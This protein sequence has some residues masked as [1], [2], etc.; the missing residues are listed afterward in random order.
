MEEPTGPGRDLQRL[1]ELPADGSWQANRQG[2]DQVE[3][4]E[5]AAGLDRGFAGGHRLR[6]QRHHAGADPEL[7]VVLYEK[8]L[9][10]NQAVGKANKV[11]ADP[12]YVEVS[13][14]QSKQQP[15]FKKGGTLSAAPGNVK[16]YTDAA[17]KK[18]LTGGALTNAQLTGKTKIYLRGTAPGKFK[19]KLAL[20]NPANARIQLGPEA[21]VE[22]GVVALGLDLYAFDKSDPPAR[23]ALADNK[24]IVPGGVI[25]VQESDLHSRAKLVLQK[26]DAADWPAGT[27]A[28]YEVVLSATNASGAAKLWDAETG[29]AEKALPLKIRR[30]D[31]TADRT[32]WLGQTATKK[33]HDIRIDAGV[34]TKRNGDWVRLTVVRIKEVKPAD[35]DAW[36]RASSRYWMRPG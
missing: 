12:T 17:C 25:H 19:L 10:A 13:F 30:T 6:D 2:L 31:L 5:R 16:F 24:K 35:A 26:V 1:G 33:L 3:C 23:T 32:Y 28:F 15:A 20:E 7:R 4:L 11:Y 22:M 9:S 34:Q 21:E 14:T 36:H 18:E 8:E 29:G 27:N